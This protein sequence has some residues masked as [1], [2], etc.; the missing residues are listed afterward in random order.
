MANAEYEKQQLAIAQEQ[1]AVVKEQRIATSKY[2]AEQLELARINNELTKTTKEQHA[3][4]N[5]SASDAVLLAHKQLAVAKCTL[6]IL[7]EHT[8]QGFREASG[9]Y[10]RGLALRFDPND[11][12]NASYVEPQFRAEIIQMLRCGPEDA[13]QLI[14]SG[15]LPRSDSY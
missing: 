1:L 10:A 7:R 14:N 8:D 13:R 6:A 15:L 3:A 12:L 2:E 11:L 9:H 5:K 4:A